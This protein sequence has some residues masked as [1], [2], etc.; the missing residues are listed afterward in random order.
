[1]V[2]FKSAV[3]SGSFGR[4]E[5]F[6]RVFLPSETVSYHDR[7][8]GRKIVR[9]HGVAVLYTEILRRPS[10]ITM[11]ISWGKNVKIAEY[12]FRTGRTGSYPGI[13]SLSRTQEISW[14]YLLLRTVMLQKKKSLGPPDSSLRGSSLWEVA[15]E[16][17]TKGDVRVRKSK[18]QSNSKKSRA[19][20]QAKHAGSNSPQRWNCSYA[21]SCNHWELLMITYRTT[22]NFCVNFK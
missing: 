8:T 19:C 9:G 15:R 6:W 20:S 10:L 14:Q 5:S 4:L 13:L 7:S 16:W 1:M 17:D 21:P 22:G 3:S 11:A 2:P 12:L 18:R